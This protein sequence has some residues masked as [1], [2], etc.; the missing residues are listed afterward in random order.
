MSFFLNNPYRQLRELRPR[1]FSRDCKGKKNVEPVTAPITFALQGIKYRIPKAKKAVIYPLSLEK[2]QL[3]FHIHIF[4]LNCLAAVH[5]FDYYKN[6][7]HA[8][9]LKALVKIG[10][11]IAW[12][13]KF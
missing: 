5:K 1:E 2:T 6:N 11:D 13:L 4:N 3:L 12:E 9:T 7:M 10:F 8:F